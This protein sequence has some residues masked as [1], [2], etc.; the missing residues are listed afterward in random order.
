[1]GQEINSGDL[2][3]DQLVRS[4][5]QCGREQRHYRIGDPV[6]EDEGFLTVDYQ[7]MGCMSVRSVIID[8][9]ST[10]EGIEEISK[11]NHKVNHKRG[12]SNF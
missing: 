2:V 8:A 11:N 4:C 5:R 3:Q 6:M 10:R 9:L 12:N 7:C 1:M